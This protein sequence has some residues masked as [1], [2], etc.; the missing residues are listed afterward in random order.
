[1]DSCASSECSWRR[2]RPSYYPV[3]TELIARFAL[4]MTAVAVAIAFLLEGLPLGAVAVVA[5]AVFVR[6]SV[7]RR[8]QRAS[9][10]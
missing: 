4:A 7:E 8:V 9:N 1:M 5:I 2:S 3:M 6:N 10:T